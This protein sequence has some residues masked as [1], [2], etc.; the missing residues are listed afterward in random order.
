MHAREASTTAVIAVDGLQGD[1]SSTQGIRPGWK[2]ELA[3]DVESTAR[4][5]VDWPGGR[6]LAWVTSSSAKNT[7]MS[8]MN[9]PPIVSHKVIPQVMM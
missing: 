8:P 1:C 5:N 9:H 4:I 3:D 6:S 7:D 2:W